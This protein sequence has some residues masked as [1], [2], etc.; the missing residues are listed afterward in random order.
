VRVIDGDT[1][2]LAGLGSTR[3]IGVDAPEVRGRAEC[4]AGEAA[5]FVRRLVPAGSTVRF[6]L[7]EDQ[8]DRYGRG[9]VYVWLPDGRSLNAVLLEGGYATVLTIPPNDRYARLFR[10][11][12]R[13][14]RRERR[15]RWS[16]ACA[17]RA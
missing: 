13:E 2:V 7:G 14:A 9:L 10:R 12:E 8:R 5:A 11:L 6:L 16:E 1:L 17:R 3:L 4:F 15:G